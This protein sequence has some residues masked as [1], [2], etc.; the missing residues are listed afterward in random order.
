MGINQW[1]FIKQSKYFILLA[2]IL[3]I[4]VLNVQAEVSDS[5]PLYLYYFETDDVLLETGQTQAYQFTAFDDEKVTIVAYGL[6]SLVRPEITLLNEA[7]ETVATGRSTLE[8]PYVRYIQFTATKDET[9]TFNVNAVEAVEGG[10]LA[11]VMLVEGE[12][13]GGDLTYLDTVNPLLPGRVFMVAGSDEIDTDVTASQVGIRTGAEVLPVVRFRD[14]PDIFVSRGSTEELP[15]IAERFNPNTSHVWFNENGN[16]FYFFTVHAIPEQVTSATEDVEYEALN[17][18]TFFYFDYFFIV[19]AGSDPVLL[20]QET[21]PCSEVTLENRVDCERTPPVQ[22]VLASDSTDELVVQP[23]EVVLEPDDTGFFGGGGC[24]F[25]WG[26]Y[27]PNSPPYYVPYYTYYYYDACESYYGSTGSAGSTINGT[28]DPDFGDYLLAGGGNDVIN[29]YAGNDTIIADDVLYYDCWA[30][31]PYYYQFVYTCYRYEEFGGYGHDTVY[32]GAGGDTIYGGGGDDFIDGG[33]GDDLIY[34]DNYRTVYHCTQDYFTYWFYYYTPQ[35]CVVYDAFSYGNGTDTING[36]EGD[37]TIYASGGNDVVNGGDDDD[38]IFGDEGNDILNGDDDDDTLNGGV[39]NDTLNGG[40]GNDIL[41]GDAGNDTLN[42]G[43]GN[44]T[45]NGGLG[46]DIL[47]GGAGMDT[48]NGGAGDDY[49]IDQPGSNVDSYDGG[50]GYDTVDYSAFPDT[51]DI[52]FTITPTGASAT[53]VLDTYTSVEAYISGEGTDFFVISGAFGNTD[54]TAIGLSGGVGTDTVVFDLIT[55]PASGYFILTGIETVNCNLL[56]CVTGPTVGD[57]TQYGTNLWVQWIT[58][59]PSPLA[60]L[61]ASERWNLSGETGGSFDGGDGDD[62]YTL[63]DSPTVAVND[64]GSDGVD[65]VI[66]AMTAAALTITTTDENNFTVSDNT[67]TVA[68]TGIEN[69]STGAAND[70]FLL[71]YNPAGVSNTYDA[72]EN[73]THTDVDTAVFDTT[74]DLT[75]TVT[76]NMAVVN[77]TDTTSVADTLVNFENIAT[78][79]GNDSFV[80][81]TAPDGHT[82]N[83]GGGRNSITYTD[84]SDT[85]VS[86]NSTNSLTVAV[87]SSSDTLLNFDTVTTGD[88]NDVV[89]LDVNAASTSTDYTVNASGGFNIFNFIFNGDP[90]TDT[91]NITVAADGTNNVLDFSG[92]NT[93]VTVDTS[94]SNPQQVFTNFWLTIQGVFEVVFGTEET[95]PEPIVETAVVADATSDEDETAAVVTLA[96]PIESCPTEPVTTTD[97]T[98]SAEAEAEAPATEATPCE[99]VA[100][101]TAETTEAL[102]EVTAE[103]TAIL[104]EATTESTSE[105]TVEVVPTLADTPE[106]TVETAPPVAATSE[107]P[108][109]STPV[110]EA[111]PEPP[112]AASTP[113]PEATEPS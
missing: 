53:V 57:F 50:L 47:N 31:N 19:G 60:A 72:G 77:Q 66:Y 87:A 79:S 68:F 94:S 13:I 41:N 99:T 73:A 96:A 34:G 35:E 102:A 64:T 7:G 44:D 105:V 5:S 48:I 12:P 46:N 18:L 39:G 89:N 95:A 20:A 2:I 14:K 29:G 10:G 51:T 61:A 32:G 81:N 67:T 85:V 98:V 91:V 78:G 101:P 70:I 40:A 88:G 37:D 97:E 92:V 80:M 42:G 36:G 113:A 3:A 103:A 25:T 27:P 63:G 1:G 11:R 71:H 8:Q 82:L 16:K 58:A 110:P 109:A 15:P 49:F 23:G 59:A 100:E 22:T 83:G 21:Q 52:T 62:I 24:Y 56:P 65:T 30:Y 17:L 84:N 69:I 28:D 26:L 38:T 111:T 54:A 93:T 104:A 55:D 33:G 75:V 76:D 74:L 112:P 90:L 45:L 106:A 43:V 4:A 9:F 6:D 108:A 107:P 86:L